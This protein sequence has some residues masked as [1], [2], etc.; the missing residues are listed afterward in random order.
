VGDIIAYGPRVE[1]SCDR[2]SIGSIVLK[3][4]DIEGLVVS[5]T[6]WAGGSEVAEE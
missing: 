5:C 4:M 2:A 6:D 3:A 1:S